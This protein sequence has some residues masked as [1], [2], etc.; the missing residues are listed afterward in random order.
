MN[1]Q[2]MFLARGAKWGRPSGGDHTPSALLFDAPGT[3]AAR[4][5]PS[6]W[7]MADMASPAKPM[8]QSARNERRDTPQPMAER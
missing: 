3:S 8:P 2:M 7:S 1:N 4:T 6:R 5:I